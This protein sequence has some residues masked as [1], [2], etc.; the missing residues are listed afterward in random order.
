MHNSLL[1][2]SLHALFYTLAS[3]LVIENASKLPSLTFDYI[4]VG[5]E[6]GPL[7]LSL[8]IHEKSIVGGTAGLVVA[9]RLSAVSSNTV[10][11]IE[12]GG[13][14]ED[15]LDI[16]I[17]LL[18]DFLAPNTPFDWNYTTTPQTGF[19]NRSLS[20]QAGH[21]LGGSS[22]ISEYS[23]RDL[24]YILTRLYQTLWCTTQD[25]KMTSITSPRCPAMTAGIG[26]LCKIS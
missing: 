9:N 7:V 8:D 3:G 11:V 18:G 16:Q 22:T 24:A 4:I 5:G 19:N 2:V 17:P 6:P 20:Y 15:V 12:A 26:I 1:T 23:H 13:S 10:L 21:V 25:Q 14:D